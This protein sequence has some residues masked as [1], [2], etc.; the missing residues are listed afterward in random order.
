M[1]DTLYDATKA[2]KKVIY[3]LVNIIDQKTTIIGNQRWKFNLALAIQGEIT[4][5]W[6]HV[7]GNSWTALLDW[8]QKNMKLSDLETNQ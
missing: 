4:K 3:Y 2:T 7:Q 5:E 1:D 6:K 8:T